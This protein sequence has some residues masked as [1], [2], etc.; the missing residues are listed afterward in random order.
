MEKIIFAE[1]IYSEFKNTEVWHCGVKL[2]NGKMYNRRDIIEPLKAYK[3]M[4]MLSRKEYI[5]IDPESRMKVLA[6]L[7]EQKAAAAAEAPVAEEKK[8][9]KPVKRTR[10]SKKTEKAA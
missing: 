8:A 5:K 6:H 2:E 9:E 7:N 4:V 3:Y 1:R 10:S